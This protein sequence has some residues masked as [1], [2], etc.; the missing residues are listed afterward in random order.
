LI[1]CNNLIK[2][3]ENKMKKHLRLPI[4]FILALLIIGML[5]DGCAPVLSSR[6]MV[7][8]QAEINTAVAATLVQ[9]IIETKVASQASGLA[10][11]PAATATPI[12]S[13]TATLE[14]TLALPTPTELPPPTATPIPTTVAYPK[15]IAEVNTNCRLGPGTRYTIDGYLAAGASSS[16][17]G[18][19]STKDWW[20]I[21]HPLKSG[22]F[23]WVWDGSTIVEG[24]TSSLPLVD[25]PVLSGVNA[26]NIYGNS[27]FNSSSGVCS[28]YGSC[29]PYGYSNGYCGGLVNGVYYPKCKPKDVFCCCPGDGWYCNPY[30]YCECNLIWKNPCKK[31]GCPPITIVNVDTYCQKYPKCCD[32]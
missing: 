12:P 11:A 21:A 31:N 3:K 32:D 22:A 2:E 9:Y 17:Y 5:L 1:F 18:R 15:I 19:D 8:V 4:T 10:A 20:Y 28:P 26:S 14:T 27:Y 23:C 30:I 25:A 7:D 29:Y 6:P 13:A 16:V 24:N